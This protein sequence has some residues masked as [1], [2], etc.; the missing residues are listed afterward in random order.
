M[1][2]MMI[3][4]H[5]GL[6]L[7]FASVSSFQLRPFQKVIAESRQLNLFTNDE[8]SAK[9][10]DSVEVEIEE[11]ELSSFFQGLGQWPLY[12]SSSVE[13]SS[14]QDVE[15]KKI[16][17]E[18]SS[19]RYRG[20]GGINTFSNLIKLEVILDLADGLKVN[21][22]EPYFASV[23]AT[24]D[25]LFKS[26]NN[27]KANV[28]E[29]EED[30]NLET[31]VEELIE[32]KKWLE[33][34]SPFEGME[35]ENKIARLSFT[36][37]SSITSNSTQQSLGQAAEAL[38]KNATSRIEY[39]VNEASKGLTPATVN[40]LIFRS[41][42]LFLT[43]STSVE[44]LT[45]EIVNVAA[46]IA[47]QNGLDVTV[48]TDRA[49]EA[50][51]GASMM[52]NVANRLFAS[53]YAYGSQSDAAGSEGSPLGV[54]LSSPDS[55]PLFADFHSARRVEP[56]EYKTVL[57]KGAEMGV[58]AGS[59]YEDTFTRCHEI[60]HSIVSNGTTADV[61][62]M[63]TD[64]IDYSTSFK[65][66]SEFVEK[67]PILVRTITIRGFDAS[68]SAVDRESLLNEICNA[69]GKP[70]NAA[71]PNIL[72]HSGLLEIATEIYK[73]V[74]NYIEWASPTHRI[75]FNGHVSDCCG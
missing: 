67:E 34:L 44:Q 48:A 42:Q 26:P 14:N 65:E 63:I 58:L 10:D 73:D 32:R 49:R 50:T 28:Q 60:G 15:N 57:I 61:A 66:D 12:P 59:I 5:F 40:D 71:K 37:S 30:I 7:V 64:S 35:V 18:K 20:Q 13:N 39:L 24:A 43:N 17:L 51:K 25:Q 41:A 11:K 52:V 9:K 69:P 21:E 68:D 2:T 56:F 4:K 16:T 47:Q 46:S 8:R 74:K 55:R 6:I 22:T 36:Q 19:G 72:F 54:D 23:I 29:E 62:W 45:N 31:T 75:V 70:I 1:M 33:G 3:M 53:G 38:M 27:A